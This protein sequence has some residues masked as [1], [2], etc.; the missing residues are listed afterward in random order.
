MGHLLYARCSRDHPSVQLLETVLLQARD[1][2]DETRITTVSLRDLD[3][4]PRLNR[5]RALL[6]LGWQGRE[7]LKDIE[8]ETGDRIDGVLEACV[9]SKH[10]ML[11]LG[12]AGPPTVRWSPEAREETWLDRLAKAEGTELVLGEGPRDEV[13][14]QALLSR[15]IE[16]FEAAR[17]PPI[18]RDGRKSS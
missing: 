10:H 6:G 1:D 11:G 13:E 15:F 16:L 9:C 17:R 8:A 12:R 7:H 4:G 18:P 2:P 3:R 5:L 14:A